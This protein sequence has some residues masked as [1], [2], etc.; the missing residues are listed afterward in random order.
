VRTKLNE[1]LKGC[2]LPCEKGVLIFI[3]DFELYE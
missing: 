3:V 1:R 2:R